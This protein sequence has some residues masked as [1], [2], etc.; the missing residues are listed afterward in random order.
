MKQRT[1]PTPGQG[2]PQ[3]GEQNQPKP[4]QSVDHGHE[5]KQ[6]PTAGQGS[7]QRSEPT[8]GQS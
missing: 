8:P 6:Q 1:E 5:I 4:G 7:S 2:N 3:T